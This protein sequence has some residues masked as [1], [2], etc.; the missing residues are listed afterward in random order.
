MGANFGLSCLS[1]GSIELLRRDSEGV[2]REILSIFIRPC[3]GQLSIT[4][5]KYLLEAIE[6]R[7]ERFSFVC[8][9]GTLNPGSGHSTRLSLSVCVFVRR[10]PW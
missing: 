3:V 4:V 8:G 10:R 1:D 9:A 6:Q 5:R 2:L 7:E